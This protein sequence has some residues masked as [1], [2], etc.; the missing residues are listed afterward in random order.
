MHQITKGYFIYSGLDILHNS[1][2]VHRDLKPANILINDKGIPK[3]T[4]FGSSR[5]IA[6]PN[7][8]LSINL[9]TKYLKIFLYHIKLNFLKIFLYHI[10]INF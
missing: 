1:F 10:K 7:R 6:S 2:I 5:Y 4:D 8:L 9:I 3:I